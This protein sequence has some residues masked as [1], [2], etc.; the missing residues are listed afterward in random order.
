[1]DHSTSDSQLNP[2][3]VDYEFESNEVPEV[4]YIRHDW[5]LTRCIV[6]PLSVV[7]DELVPKVGMTFT[8][9]EDAGKFYKN[10]AKAAGFSTR[11]RCTNRK[12][13][14]IKNQ[15]ITCS[16]EG[17]WKSKISP[18]EK[19]NPTAGLNCPARIYIHTLKDVGAW[20]ISKVVLDHSHPCCPSKAEMLKQH[21]EL[22][23]SIRR[24]IENN[25]EAGIRPSKTY[26][27]FVAAAGGHRELNFIEKDVKNYI[28]REVRN[29]SEQEDAKEFGKYLA[30]EACMPTTIHCWCIW[31]IMKKI[32]SKLNRYKGHAD[33]EQEMSQVVWNSHNKDSFDRNW[34]DFLQSFGLADNKWLSGNVFLKSAAEVEQAERESDVA[35][36]HTVIPCATKSSIEAQFQ[37]AYTHVKF[38]EVQAQFRGKANCIT[39]LKNSALGYSV[40]KVGEQVSSSIFNKFV[41]TYDSVAAEVKCE[42]LLFESRGILCRHALSVLSFEQASQVSPRYI[43]ERWSKKVKRRHTHIKSSHDEPLMEPRSKRFDQL[44][45]RSQNICEFA[46]ESE[47][48]TAILHRAYDNVMAEMEALKAKRKG[49]SSLSHEDANL[50]SVNELQS[51]PRI[52]TRGRPKNRLGSKLEKQIANGTKK[53][54]MKVLSEINL[55]DAASAAHSNSSQYQGHVMN[56]Q[57]RVPAAGDNSLG[58]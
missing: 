26:Q 27:S 45:F 48:L 19:T 8:T 7:D 28:T 58:V 30:L 12:G 22:S 44:V 54:K 23:M 41:V 53:K 24:T 49:T 18:T 14:E 10:Y 5:F 56:Y 43:L 31:H 36:F 16:R 40:Y 3:E 46:S 4:Y 52:R 35:D 57:F 13:N 29:V 55:F 20:I 21:R 33:I 42:C 11:V 9:L 2:G 50:E 47:E 39:R 25:E 32:P 51:P 15:L 34:N 17:K 38:R 6:Q 1:M 37:D